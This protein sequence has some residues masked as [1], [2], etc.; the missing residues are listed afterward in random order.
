[1]NIVVT[2]ASS[3]IGKDFCELILNS[4]KDVKILGVGRNEVALNELKLK[5]EG[6]FDYVIADLS[7]LDDAYRVVDE[8]GKRLGHVDVLLNNAGFGLYRDVLSHQDEEI[9]SL[10]NVNLVTPYILTRELVKYMD[11][12]SSVVNVL[13][14]GIYVLMLKLPIYG[15]SKLA[16]YYITEAL[17]RELRDKGIR[18]ISVFPGIVNTEFHR[19]AGLKEI[20]GGIPAEVV[21]KAILKALESGRKEVYVP[22]YLRILKIVGP[23]L[24][25]FT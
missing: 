23:K 14:A 19:R 6:R 5:Y 4:K 2:G 22:W 15:A 9:I 8:V 10:L 11:A 3:G 20:R 17:R 13:T 25:P 18:V 24:F 7:K 16:L 1:M 21:A 12:G